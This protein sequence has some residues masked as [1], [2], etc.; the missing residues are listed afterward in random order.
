MTHIEKHGMD[1]DSASAYVMSISELLTPIPII[2]DPQK[3]T[4]KELETIAK[5]L[6]IHKPRD[7]L[8]QLQKTLEHFREKLE[9][10]FSITDILL[11]VGDKR[12]E[13]TK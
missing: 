7:D 12:L 6:D 11:M 3:V 2:E 10:N 1:R 9:S 8:D 4:H 5:Y 13:I